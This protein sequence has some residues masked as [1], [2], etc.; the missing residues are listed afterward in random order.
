MQQS[1]VG[2]LMTEWRSTLVKG[3]GGYSSVWRCYR[4][5][6]AHDISRTLGGIYDGGRRLLT[7]C[8][9]VL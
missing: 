7:E 3:E 2:E 9:H 8:M 1:D 4:F 5:Y 6:R